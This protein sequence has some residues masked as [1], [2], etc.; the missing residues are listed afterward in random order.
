MLEIDILDSAREFLLNIE[1]KF[2][3]Q[4]R[5]RTNR[6]AKQPYPPQ[7]KILEGYAPL[8]RLRSG[9]Y[10]II[11]F[12]EGNVLKIPLIDKRGDDKVYRRI[13]QKFKS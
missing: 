7:S 1:R 13:E 2:A 10:R 11:Y 6:L 8:R 4:I 12:A 3:R 9:D 5:T